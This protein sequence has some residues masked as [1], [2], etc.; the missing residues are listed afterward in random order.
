[1]HAVCPVKLY[2]QNP[3]AG[4]GFVDSQV[5]G[6]DRGEATTAARRGDGGRSWQAYRALK[7]EWVRPSFRNSSCCRC[8]GV[9][10]KKD[11]G[12]S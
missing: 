10:L 2:L 4:P 7:G 6:G 8:R 5:C 1:M 11:A 3:G 9:S 12:L